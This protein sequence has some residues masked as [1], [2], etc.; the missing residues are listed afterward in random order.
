MEN[1]LNDGK[2]RIKK[3]VKGNEILAVLQ[4]EL[5]D[6]HGAR[7][8]FVALFVVGVLKV[9]LVR[10]SSIAGA[11]DTEAQKASAL[12][13]IERFLGKYKVD[14]AAIAGLVVRVVGLWGVDKWVLTLDRT[15][16]KLGRV[17]LNILMLAVAYKGVAVPLFWKVLEGDGIS[18]QK[19]R[20]DLLGAFRSCFGKERI[21]CLVGDREFIGKDWFDYLLTANIPFVLRLRENFYVTKRGRRAMLKDW[22]AY[23]PKGKVV[24]AKR[25][26]DL[27]GNRVYL[28]ALKLPNQYLFLAAP[29]P[30]PP[31]LDWYGQR[32]EIETL[33]K[34]L[35][36]SGFNLEDTRLTHPDRLSKLLALLSIAFGWCYKAGVY[37]DQQKPMRRVRLKDDKGNYQT[38]RLYS[39]FKYGLDYLQTLLLNACKSKQLEQFLTLLSG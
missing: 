38:L 37:L 29:Q 32:W 15:E 31:V 18:S 11:M 27:K 33:F 22:F 14:Y 25:P 39:F 7:I 17:H 20:E 21:E 8:K 4:R 2:K 35:K 16:W 9:G 36:T 30:C 10:L 23:L 3:L 5:S 13:R 6:W 19:E 24:Q 26:F 28:T 12:K 1:V 34:A